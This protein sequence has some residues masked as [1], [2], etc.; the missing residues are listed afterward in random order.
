MGRCARSNSG[1]S[2]GR[3]APR[4]VARGLPMHARHLVAKGSATGLKPEL[5]RIVP[6]KADRRFVSGL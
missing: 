4:S 5:I 1:P 3:D 6:K 2:L